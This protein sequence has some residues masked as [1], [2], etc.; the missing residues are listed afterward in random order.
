MVVLQQN[1][2]RISLGVPCH[3]TAEPWVAIRNSYKATKG[4]CL[5][6]IPE[7]RLLMH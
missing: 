6:N 7:A 2:S 1:V 3:L 4:L 5:C